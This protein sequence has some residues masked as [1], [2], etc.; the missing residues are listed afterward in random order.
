MAFFR[1]RTGLAVTAPALL[2][3]LAM[4]LFVPFP[5][6]TG[7][8][9]RLFFAVLL[10]GFAGFGA[11]SLAGI[12]ALI[13]D[14][15]VTIRG[16]GRA[17]PAL[18]LHHKG[19]QPQLSARKQ[20][21]VR[22]IVRVMAEHGLFAPEAPDPA[23]LYAGVAERDFPVKPDS[24]LE[25]LCE[26][27]YYHPGTDPEHWMANLVMHDS[28]GEQDVSGQIA[29]IARLAGG[30][31][32]VRDAVVRHGAV[33]GHRRAV[34]VDV[35]MTVNG[36]AVVLSWLGDVKYLS[37]HIHH[38]LATRLRN[39]GSGKRLAWLWDDQGAWMSM[40]DDGAV[41]SINAALKLGDRARCAWGWMDEGEPMAAGQMFIDQGIDR[42]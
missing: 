23:L 15:A 10:G 25:A 27:D 29:D 28:K 40:V 33:P 12:P 36:E 22:R 26:V 7:E 30:A 32:D 5:A 18:S 39:G 19:P 41:E 9:R 1:S 14:M 4:F 37:T 38:A 20:A 21:E 8:G 3:A 2:V 35:T 31:L 13:R 34:Q 16:A 11:W 17:P 6:D 24:I 42:S